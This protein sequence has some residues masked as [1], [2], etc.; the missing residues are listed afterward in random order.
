MALVF[1]T[2]FGVLAGAGIDALHKGRTPIYVK[3]G[4]SSSALQVRL[5]F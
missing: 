5:R 2:G 1:N 4:K 3:T